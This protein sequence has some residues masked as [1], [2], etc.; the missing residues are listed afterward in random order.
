MRSA[1]LDVTEKP[2]AYRE[3]DKTKI[4]DTPFMFLKKALFVDDR[5]YYAY[6]WYEFGFT[7]S[8]WY[9]PTDS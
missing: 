5:Q 3:P 6:S 4:T 1:C 7:A 2:V 9:V 8:R